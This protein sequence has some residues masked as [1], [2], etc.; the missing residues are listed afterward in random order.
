M[1]VVFEALSGDIELSMGR[2]DRGVLDGLIRKWRSAD[3]ETREQIAAEFREL[4][5]VDN[6][7]R[8]SAAVLFFEAVPADDKGELLR[9][10]R[11]HPQLFAHEPDPWFGKGEL[12]ALVATALSKRMISDEIRTAVRSEA[13]RPHFGHRVLAGLLT[14]DRTWALEHV[15]ELVIATPEAFVRYIELVD[16]FELPAVVEAARSTLPS[17]VFDGVIR[18]GIKD[19]ALRAAVRAL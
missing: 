7:M 15:A 2:H 8:R 9:A 18:Y 1:G 4:L 12:R 14:S 16:E 10:L 6:V 11:S 19:E 17:D 13:L 5:T 3:A